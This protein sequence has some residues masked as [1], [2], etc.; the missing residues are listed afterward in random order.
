[1][2]N[3]LRMQVPPTYLNSRLDLLKIVEPPEKYFQNF[4]FYDLLFVFPQSAKFFAND[5][6][7]RKTY[8]GKFISFMRMCE[9]FLEHSNAII[10][11]ACTIMH[12]GRL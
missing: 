5:I 1:M 10:G 12:G 4:L 7:F 3:T 6:I 9:V 8:N 11:L 2:K